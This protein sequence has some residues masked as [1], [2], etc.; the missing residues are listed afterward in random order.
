M[1]FDSDFFDRQAISV[2][3]LL[4]LCYQTASNA[5][6][7]VLENIWRKSVFHAQLKSLVM[8]F[9]RK[10]PLC[11]IHLIAST[12]FVPTCVVDVSRTF[13]NIKSG[14][15]YLVREVVPMTSL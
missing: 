11:L 8:I 4:T 9:Y 1:F 3:M 5:E 14:N 7:C 12:A 13:V 15:T 10:L 2:L 6:A